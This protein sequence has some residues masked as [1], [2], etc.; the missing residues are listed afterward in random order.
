MNQKSLMLEGRLRS[1]CRGSL[2]IRGDA[3]KGHLMGPGGDTPFVNFMH[4][5]VFEFLDNTDAL[6][7]DCL[8]ID[9]DGFDPTAALAFIDSFMLFLDV[10]H[11]DEGDFTVLNS[12]IILTDLLKTRPSHL[13]AVLDSILMAIKRPRSSMDQHEQNKGY[14]SR[15]P[16]RLYIGLNNEVD[17]TLRFFRNKLNDKHITL[18]LAAELNPDTCISKP[19]AQEFDTVQRARTT[20]ERLNLLVPSVLQPMMKLILEY[21]IDDRLVPVTTIGILLDS[22]CDPNQMVVEH[23]KNTTP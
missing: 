20:S 10:R 17:L 11:I 21:F 6:K 8:K 14:R 1:Q 7:M 23:Y 18:L 13:A 3:S 19:D 22:G 5:T 2:E 16:T 15:S 4:R 9:D 12:L